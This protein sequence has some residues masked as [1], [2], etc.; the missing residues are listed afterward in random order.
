[1]AEKTLIF[2]GGCIVRNLGSSDEGREPDY[3]PSD[4]ATT[5]LAR[6]YKGL[7]N[8]G[9]NGVIEIWKLNRSET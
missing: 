4:I 3:K 6:D 7:N 9:S 5:L 2:R 1:M 8:Y